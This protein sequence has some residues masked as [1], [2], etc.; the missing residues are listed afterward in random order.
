MNLRRQADFIRANSKASFWVVL[1]F[2]IVSGGLMRPSSICL[3]TKTTP[4][5]ILDLEFAFGQDRAKLVRSTWKETW[6]GNG[7]A[8]EHALTNIAWDFLFLTAYTI[9]FIVLIVIVLPK[10]NRVG[11]VF[12]YLAFIAGFLDSV[13]NLFMYFFLRGADLPSLIFAIPATIKFLLVTILII[14]LLIQLAA[15]FLGARKHLG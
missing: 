10:R 14:K 1:V 7:N 5:A 6:C 15:N 12:I 4:I 3:K 13:E 11:S 9:F 2:V 8:I